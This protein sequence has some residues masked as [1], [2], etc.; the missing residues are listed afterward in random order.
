MMAGLRSAALQHSLV[1]ES[2]H[3][4]F[5]LYS[6]KSANYDNDSHYYAR[7]VKDVTTSSNKYLNYKSVCMQCILYLEIM[8]SS[9]VS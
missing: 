7:N 8:Y 5:M 4:H 2:G 3:L 6:C 9:S 1:S